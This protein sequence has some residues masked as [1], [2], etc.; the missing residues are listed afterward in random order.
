MKPQHLISTIF[1]TA[2]DYITVRHVQEI[3]TLY[4]QYKDNPIP[5][6]DILSVTAMNLST[7]TNF[8][9]MLQHHRKRDVL[10]VE[11]LLLIKP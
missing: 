10:Y 4:Q 6:A 9:G 8:P 3:K 5:S 11:I 1:Q 2:M 7:P